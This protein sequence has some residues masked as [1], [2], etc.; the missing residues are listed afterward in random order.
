MNFGELI[1]L[2]PENIKKKHCEKLENK[3]ANTRVAILLN[4]T[5]LN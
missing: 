4:K 1:C 3:L 5:C 2:Q